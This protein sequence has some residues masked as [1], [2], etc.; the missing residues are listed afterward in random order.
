MQEVFEIPTVKLKNYIRSTVLSYI[1]AK[2]ELY[3]TYIDGMWCVEV[4]LEKYCAF[5]TFKEN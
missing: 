4:K 3:N 2:V 1:S 5:Y